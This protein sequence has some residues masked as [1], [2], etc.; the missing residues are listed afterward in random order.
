HVYQGG[1]GQA[2]SAFYMRKGMT[3]VKVR[4]LAIEDSFVEHGKVD[5]LRRML[6][7]DSDSVVKV[8]KEYL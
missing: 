2:V 3:E 8:I 7:I 4:N 1:Y 6:G 5:E